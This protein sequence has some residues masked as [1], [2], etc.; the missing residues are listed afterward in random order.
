M[1][2][3]DVGSFF[4]PMRLVPEESVGMYMGIRGAGSPMYPR[5]NPKR[6]R[7]NLFSLEWIH[8]DASVFARREGS[9]SSTNHFVKSQKTFPL[10]SGD[11]LLLDSVT[12]HYYPCGR[13]FADSLGAKLLFIP[14][15][16][17]CSNCIGGMFSI[18]KPNDRSTGRIAEAF[19]ARLHIG[20]HFVF[21]PHVLLGAGRSSPNGIEQCL[22]LKKRKFQGNGIDT[23]LV[24]PGMRL[25][26]VVGDGRKILFSP[27]IERRRASDE[28]EG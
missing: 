6:A 7:T 24:G 3:R 21:L 1:I 12:F 4:Q 28:E 9:Y 2:L 17:P 23:Q 19:S 11:I 5:S 15:C 13:A 18:V 20:A 16:A 27:A 26:S 25:S 14:P 22:Q 8:L 10:A